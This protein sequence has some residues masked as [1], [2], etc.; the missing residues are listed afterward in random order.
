MES[1]HKQLVRLGSTNPELRPHIRQLLAA[2]KPSAADKA[3]FNIMFKKMMV[4]AESPGDQD[5][6][7]DL[8][9]SFLAGEVTLKDIREEMGKTASLK[10]AGDSSTW[11]YRLTL[12]QKKFIQEVVED[13]ADTAKMEGCTKV[14]T[15]GAFVKGFYKDVA[16]EVSYGFNGI[17]TMDVTTIYAGQKY[18]RGLKSFK[19]LVGSPGQVA[20]ESLYQHF[21]GFIS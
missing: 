8:K 11:S 21:E 2:S 13:A 14:T 6:L 5:D 16:F 20:S 18:P 17:S 7:E 9:E 4:D 1:L 3:A 15:N 19:L 12:L 10:T